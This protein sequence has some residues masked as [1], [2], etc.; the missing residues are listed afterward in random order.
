MSKYK[1][2]EK[3]L[4][5]DIKEFPIAIVEKMLERQQEQKGCTNIKT[6]QTAVSGAFQWAS[7]SEGHTFWENVI[8]YKYFNIFF[9]KY[10]KN[11]NY[12]YIYQDGTKNGDDIIET[13]EARGGV[14]KFALKADEYGF[15]YYID[16]INKRI[17]KLNVLDDCCSF[18]QAFYTELEVQPSIK[19]YTMQEIA[20]KLGINVNELRIKK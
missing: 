3:D 15:M 10:P 20:D 17:R 8:L 19:E 7:T 2:T 9:K 13:L 18:L 6:L 12:V 14:N 1:V 11:N 16:A 4:I 5:G